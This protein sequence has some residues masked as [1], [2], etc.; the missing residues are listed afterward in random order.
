[1][2]HISE[3]FKGGVVGGDGSHGGRIPHDPEVSKPYIYI[4]IYICK[5]RIL[6]ACP[7]QKMIISLRVSFF[8][9]SAVHGT[10][11]EMPHRVLSVFFLYKLA[12]LN[13]SP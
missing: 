9:I 1:M 7:A 6:V 4:N 3:A 11:C 8:D 5:S 2:Q 13:M 10:I 12:F